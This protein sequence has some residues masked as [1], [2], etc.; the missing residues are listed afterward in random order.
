MYL[1]WIPFLNLKKNEVSTIVLLIRAFVN[2]LDSEVNL[3][4]YL[5]SL[6]A[7]Y[8]CVFT[9]RHFIGTNRV[10]EIWLDMPSRSS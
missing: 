1:I 4:N 5:S 8:C 2:S 6:S 3:Y 9:R 10:S 7:N